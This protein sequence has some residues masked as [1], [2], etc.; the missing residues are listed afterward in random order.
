MVNPILTPRGAGCCTPATDVADLKL[1]TTRG[2]PAALKYEHAAWS[3]ATEGPSDNYLKP[4]LDSLMMRDGATYQSE[5]HKAY[6]KFGPNG[7]LAAQ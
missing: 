5:W 1:S 6:E 3:Y 2:S 4:A 7:S